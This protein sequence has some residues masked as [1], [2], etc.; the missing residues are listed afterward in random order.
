MKKHISVIAF[1]LSLFLI[2][3]ALF[4][5]G[6]NVGENIE[7]TAEESSTFKGS[8]GSNNDETEAFESESK[9]IA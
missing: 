7:S 6:D 5:C 1:L 3:S 2:S 9:V 4:S 8:E